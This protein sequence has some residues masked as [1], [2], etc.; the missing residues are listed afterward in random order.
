MRGSVLCGD[1]SLYIIM[2]GSVRRGS[3]IA[4]L[5][6]SNVILDV[7]NADNAEYRVESS[8]GLD[9]GWL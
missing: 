6:L 9:S 7:L 8:K 2:R 1:V 5:I 4:P 3:P